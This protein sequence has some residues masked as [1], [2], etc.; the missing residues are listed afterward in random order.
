MNLKLLLKEYK[1]ALI[2]PMVLLLILL[3][4]TSKTIIDLTGNVVSDSKYHTVNKQFTKSGVYLWTPK[5]TLTINQLEIEGDI[6]GTGNV[7]ISLIKGGKKIVL[8]KR[9]VASTSV[10]AADYVQLA[11]GTDIGLTLKYGEGDWDSDNDGLATFSDGIDFE[12]EP[13]F[14]YRFDNSNLCALWEV[15]SIETEEFTPVCYGAPACCNFLGPS[16][17]EDTWNEEFVLVKGNQGSTANNI[18]LGRVVF[19]N[20][21][22]TSYSNYDALTAKFISSELVSNSNTSFDTLF[23]S[24]NYLIRIILG[25]NTQFNFKGIKYSTT[26][27][28]SESNDDVDEVPVIA[29]KNEEPEDKKEEVFN[30]HPGRRFESK[31]VEDPFNLELNDNYITSIKVTPPY[32]LENFSIDVSITSNETFTRFVQFEPDYS[33]EAV[34]YIK[35]PLKISDE[36]ELEI[37]GDVEPVFLRYDAYYAYYRATAKLEDFGIRFRDKETAVEEKEQLSSFRKYSVYFYFIISLILA[38]A[39]FVL[40]GVNSPAINRFREEFKEKVEKTKMAKEFEKLKQIEKKIEVKV[41]KE[42]DKEIGK[43]IFED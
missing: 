34:V 35:V 1:I 40:L 11:E 15:Y 43:K 2:I 25:E 28:R 12:L 19:Y 20:G 41:E 30:P 33:Y 24:E 7:E 5:E 6:F 26:G 42:I 22:H 29:S 8:F 14:F 38:L 32:Y 3:V 18:V 21:T 4:M 16:S 31:S 9:A 23:D 36:K 37:T 17:S 13:L 27:G 39:L 10:N